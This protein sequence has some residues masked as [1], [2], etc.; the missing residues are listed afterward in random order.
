MKKYIC[1]DCK[2][3][4]TCEDG[5]L[6]YCSFCGYLF[7]AKDIICENQKQPID[8]ESFYIDI[9]DAN[10][11][12]IADKKANIPQILKIEFPNGFTEDEYENMALE[13]Y[14]ENA[15]GFSSYYTSPE[16]SRTMRFLYF[17]FDSIEDE[18]F[19]IN[20]IAH[21]VSHACFGICKVKNIAITFEENEIFALLCGKLSGK[22][23]SYLK[24][25]FSVCKN[26]TNLIIQ[27][28][29]NER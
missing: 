19:L 24:N 20:V 14:A 8:Y 2:E 17:N 4:F 18:E 15:H 9:L 3:T 7:K 16:T 22:V 27:E 25:K 10:L 5:I 6:N 28:G 12:V 13:K 21:E 29:T 23:Y 11:V 1:C 26:N